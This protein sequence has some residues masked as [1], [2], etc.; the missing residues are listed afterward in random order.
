MK[1]AMKSLVLA[2]EAPD[3]F[4]LHAGYEGKPYYDAGYLDQIDDLWTQQGLSAVMPSVVQDMVKFGGHYYAVPLDILLLEQ[5][6][7]QS[8]QIRTIVLSPTM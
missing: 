4:Q 2:G 6:V 7:T 3:S 8:A 1:A 5:R